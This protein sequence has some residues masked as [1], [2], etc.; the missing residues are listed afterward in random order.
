[1]DVNVLVVFYSRY[2]ETEKLALAAGVGAIQA[3]ANIRLRR[4]ADLADAEIIQSDGA[5]SQNLERMNKDYIAPREIDSQWADVLILA[6]PQ[7]R[8]GEMEQYLDS[9]RESLHGKI[10]AVLGGFGDAAA[11]AGLTI[12]PSGGVPDDSDSAL[13][14]GRR[15]AESGRSKKLAMEH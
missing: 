6:A 14:Y 13:A 10:A 5:W 12:V 2:G 11:L 15:A 1:V 9:S 8:T 7:G 3:R 4:L